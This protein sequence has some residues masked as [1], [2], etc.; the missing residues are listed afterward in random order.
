MKDLEGKVD[1]EPKK[2]DT[3]TG[4]FVN[5]NSTLSHTHTEGRPFLLPFR[6]FG[7][8]PPTNSSHTH[9]HIEGRPSSSGHRLESSGKIGRRQAP[10]PDS[11]I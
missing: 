9:T 10:C 3:Y 7:E 11:P 8:I 6:I 4:M 5:S 1:M 2:F